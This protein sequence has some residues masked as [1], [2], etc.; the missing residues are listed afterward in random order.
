MYCYKLSL[1]NKI[2][3]IKQARS[4]IPKYSQGNKALRKGKK[5][6]WLFCNFLGATVLTQS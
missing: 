2:G 4:N 1:S 3:L 5:S 6:S